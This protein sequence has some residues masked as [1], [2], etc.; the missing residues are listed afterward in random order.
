MEWLDRV[1]SWLSPKAAFE[2]QAYR[3]ALAIKERQRQTLRNYDTGLNTHF[4]NHWNV[5]GVASTGKQNNN[6]L[7]IDLENGIGKFIIGLVVV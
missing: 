7:T 4:N 6:F 5:A 3:E 2:R 1:V